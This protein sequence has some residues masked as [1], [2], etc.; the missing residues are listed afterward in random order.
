MECSWQ[1]D[2]KE[3]W[4]QSR[5]RLGKGSGSTAVTQLV[6]AR[7]RTGTF[8]AIKVLV[9]SSHHLLLG[10]SDRPGAL[11]LGHL[12]HLLEGELCEIPHS[13]RF[14]FPACRGI[15]TTMPTLFWLAQTFYSYI[16]LLVNGVHVCDHRLS[17]NV[18]LGIPLKTRVEVAWGEFL[19][20]RSLPVV[21]RLCA[22]SHREVPLRCQGRIAYVWMFVVL[23]RD[24]ALWVLNFG[25]G[26]EKRE[27]GLRR[28]GG[29]SRLF[30]LILIKPFLPREMWV[31]TTPLDKSSFISLPL[32]ARGTRP[33]PQ[34]SGV[35]LITVQVCCEASGMAGV[36]AKMIM[37][38]EGT[39]T[40]SF[41]FTLPTHFNGMRTVL[42]MLEDRWIQATSNF[43]GKKRGKNEHLLNIC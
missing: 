40:L 7:A 31:E 29:T 5:G 34:V 3:A 1:P 39:I 37:E 6:R 14:T 17:N 2:G 41:P 19:V 12:S 33:G 8:F 26:S 4:D 36:L 11:P 28:A 30:S 16:F 9:L 13:M 27:S 20:W 15:E 21:G 35:H 23:L 18:I 43:M 24:L 10:I 22:P 38:T 42:L 25:V 32:G